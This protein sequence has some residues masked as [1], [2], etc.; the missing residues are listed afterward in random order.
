MQINSRDSKAIRVF[1]S[2][3]MGN[4]IFQFAFS[5][6]LKQEL[7]YMSEFLNL[8]VARR[9]DHANFDLIPFV[10][11]KSFLS[12]PSS[13]YLKYVSYTVDPW[14][15]L[16]MHAV[17]GQRFDFRF[18]HTVSPDSLPKFNTPSHIV[19]YFQNYEFV[20]KVGSIVL[21]ILSK[22]VKK[23]TNPVFE[24][25]N[26]EAI[27]IRGGDFLR[28]SNRKT[29]GSL[30][31][32]YYNSLLPKKSSLPR[33]VITD[34]L[35][36]AQTLLKEVHVDMYFDSSNHNFRESLF[37]LGNARRI[38]T[39]NS[40]FSWLGG[41]FGNEINQ[42]EVVQPIPFFRSSRLNYG[43]KLQNPKFRKFPSNWA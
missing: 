35:N 20:S 6:F 4:Q 9:I 28:P 42:A 27:H 32:D 39:A 25:S 1:A 38:Y 13:N 43:A 34:D 11:D 16:R 36:H 12:D 17:W 3:G 41:F 10:D 37:I 24:N 18:D 30:S 8:K 21:Q 5:A 14:R 7:N 40:T 22:V 29:I 19:G 31:Y 33:I 23:P 15:S 2:G 26:Y